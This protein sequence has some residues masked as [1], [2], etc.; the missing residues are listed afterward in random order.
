[1]RE[2][3]LERGDQLLP[4]LVTIL[5][6][7]NFHSKLDGYFVVERDFAPGSFLDEHDH[8]WA[9]IAMVTAEEFYAHTASKSKTRA[10][11]KFFRCCPM[12]STQRVL[13]PWGKVF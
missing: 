12:R 1:M 10:V 8:E 3:C 9:V 6:L 5:R 2:P 4:S 13:A 7:Q 11:G